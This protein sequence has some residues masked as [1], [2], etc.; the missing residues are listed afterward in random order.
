MELSSS[1]F[2]YG[3]GGVHAKLVAATRTTDGLRGIR[4]LPRVRV[5]YSGIAMLARRKR[6][7]H[8]YDSTQMCRVFSFAKRYVDT[9]RGSAAM[10]FGDGRPLPPTCLCSLW[11]FWGRPYSCGR[12]PKNK[13]LDSPPRDHRTRPIKGCSPLH[14]PVLI[15]LVEV[16]YAFGLPSFSYLSLK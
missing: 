15:P 5:R 16:G 7:Q 12:F 13:R 6:L 1:L 8:V 11:L 3:Y 14:P 10:H 9:R 2:L 4:R